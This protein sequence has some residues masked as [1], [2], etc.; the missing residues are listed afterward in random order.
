MA[1]MI[2]LVICVINVGLHLMVIYGLIPYQWVNGGRSESLMDAQQTSGLSIMLTLIFALIILIACR[3]MPVRL[4][5]RVGLI[6]TVFLILTL[7]LTF[8][9]IIYQFLGT[10][11]EKCFTGIITIVAFGIHARIAFEKR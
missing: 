10:P 8:V 11:F 6:I 4:N 9:S 1:G 7:P 2:G 5:R 3:M